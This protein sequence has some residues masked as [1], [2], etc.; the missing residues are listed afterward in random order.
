MKTL[1]ERVETGA[2]WL[3]K[4]YS[5]WVARIDLETLNQGANDH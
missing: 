5:G 1:E 2:K 4:H 3:D